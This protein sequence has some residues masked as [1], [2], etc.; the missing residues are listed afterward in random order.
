MKKLLIATLGLLP[1]TALLTQHPA[2]AESAIA[3]SATQGAQSKE[4]T[5]TSQYDGLNRQLA[6]QHAAPAD[7]MG[8]STGTPSRGLATVPPNRL[9]LARGQ[10][11]SR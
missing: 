8:N 5:Q 4:H 9:G 11:E 6:T 2:A 1:L 3:A 10:Q 7:S